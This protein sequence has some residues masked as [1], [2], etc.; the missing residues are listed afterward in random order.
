MRPLNMHERSSGRLTQEAS[1]R[2][3]GGSGGEA[4]PSGG[5]NP[6]PAPGRGR[7]YPRVGPAL[8]QMLLDA[9]RAREQRAL[10]RLAADV[11]QALTVTV[12]TES[13]TAG[14]SREG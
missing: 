3:T 14:A 5:S 4:A 13:V 11:S 9:E 7:S 12:C 8:A 1:L 2:L 10:G 6:V